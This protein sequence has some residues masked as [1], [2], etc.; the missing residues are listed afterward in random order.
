MAM[1]IGALL[2]KNYKAVKQE[3]K[4]FVKAAQGNFTKVIIDVAFLK[5]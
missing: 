1:N 5:D 3:F 4:D 2:D